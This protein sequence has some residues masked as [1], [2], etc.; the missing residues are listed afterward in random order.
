MT[1]QQDLVVLCA[2]EDAIGLQ[3]DCYIGLPPETVH[4]LKQRAQRIRAQMIHSVIEMGRE[5]AEGRQEIELFR[6][7]GFK[8]WAEGQVGIS[9]RY[10]RMLIDVYE[11]FGKTE[12]ISVSRFVD[13]ALLV[14]AAPSVSSVARVEALRRAGLGEKITVARAK[15]IIQ[16][17]R[18]QNQE[19][20]NEGEMSV[21]LL[22]EMASKDAT[23][24]QLTERITSLEKEIAAGGEGEVETPSPE[25]RAHLEALQ[26]KITTLTEQRDAL[27]KHAKVLA[28][29]LEAWREGHRAQREREARTLRLHQRWRE[30]TTAF[31]KQVHKLLL[32]FPQPVET[33]LFETEEWQRLAHVE[34]LARRFLAQCQALHE[35][36]RKVIIDA[37]P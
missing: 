18:V 4:T 21:V 17:G 8:H 12:I 14:L 31:T 29:D 19:M 37:D 27:A 36:P 34:D 28:A 10:A 1:D 24:T 9:E 16:E 23:I 35:A 30:S 11:C 7:G 3:E 33:E 25:A 26:G 20:E 5:L 15:A 22:E 6:D 2:A 32:Q 13:T